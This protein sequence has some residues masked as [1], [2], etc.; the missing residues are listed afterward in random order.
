MFQFKLKIVLISIGSEANLLYH[1]FAGIGF[2]LLCL[3]F[4][5]IEVLLIV[6]NLTYRRI[7]LCRNLYKIK[8]LIFSDSQRLR[9]G[10]YTLLR[11]IVSYQTNFWGSNCLVNSESIL[12]RRGFLGTSLILLSIVINALIVRLWRSYIRTLFNRCCDRLILL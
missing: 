4:L 2:H 5:L 3:L 6:N 10:V 7:H 12:I 8:F 11:N 1:H 9:K